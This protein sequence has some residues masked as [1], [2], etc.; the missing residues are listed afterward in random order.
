MASL[1]RVAQFPKDRAHPKRL[2]RELRMIQELDIR[3]EG[4]HVDMDD[5]LA[6]VSVRF[7]VEQLYIGLV[8][9]S[10]S[11][12]IETSTPVRRRF[13]LLY[14]EDTVRAWIKPKGHRSRTEIDT[15]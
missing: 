10:H 14:L 9:S 3:K 1:N 5:R 12:I 7:E 6:Q 13:A 4:V 8:T 15:F 2:P 11:A